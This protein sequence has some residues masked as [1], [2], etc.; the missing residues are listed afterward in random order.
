MEK[1]YLVPTWDHS[2]EFNDIKLINLLEEKFPLLYE[3]ENKRISIL[4]SVSPMKEFPPS[5]QRKYD[6]HIK[7]TSTIYEKMNLPK[8]IIVVK[9]N[10]VFEEFISK[11]K[12]SSSYESGITVHSVPKEKINQ[13]LNNNYEEKINNFIK[14]INIQNTK[15]NNKQNEDI[16]QLI[17]Y[18]YKKNNLQ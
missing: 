16:K 10:D 5:A 17:K 7:K 6:E 4:Y 3:L 11:T 8:H 15:E 2:V 9:N 18:I 1:Y 13:V 12:V 14:K